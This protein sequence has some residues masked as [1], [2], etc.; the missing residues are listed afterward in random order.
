MAFSPA[1]F[2]H[3]SRST[4]ILGRGEGGRKWGGREEV[5]RE[6]GREEEGRGEAVDL[7]GG[8]EAVGLVGVVGPA[9]APPTPPTT[10][11]SRENTRRRD[12]VATAMRPVCSQQARHVTEECVSEGSSMISAAM[13]FW[14]GMEPRR[15]EAINIRMGLSEESPRHLK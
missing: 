3:M 2:V 15:V 7:I 9:P 6:K 13:R 10:H 4:S 8:S 14:F 5:G 12:S 11:P 1:A